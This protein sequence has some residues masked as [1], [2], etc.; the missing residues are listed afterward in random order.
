LTKDNSGIARST[1]LYRKLH[2]WVA[3]PLL[4]FLLCTGVTGLLLGWKKHTGLLPPTQ[5]GASIDSK[6]WIS[7]DSIRQI[8]QAY[9]KDT[10]RQSAE[11]DR[12]DIRPAKAVA[13]VVFTSC[14]IP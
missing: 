2:R 10:L 11:I 14:I 13:K 9:I 4:V 12:I 5:K 7:I 6:E 1:R 3:I 8:S